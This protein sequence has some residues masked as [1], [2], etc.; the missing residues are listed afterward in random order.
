MNSRVSWSVDG[1]DPSVRERA[2]A[3]ARRAGMSL[4]D[5]LNSTIGEPIP[6]SFSAP[7]SQRPAMPSRESRDVADIHQRLDSITKQIEQ[8][9]R[10]AP[11]GETP[12]GE[13]PGEPTVA[14][15]LND[16]ISRLDARLSQISNPAPTRQAQMQ[17]KQRQ[18]EHG[19]AGR[20]P[21]LSP[22]AAAQSGLAGF[23][24]RRNRRA[25]E[26]TRQSA[27]APDAAAPCRADGRSRPAQFLAAQFCATRD[28]GGAGRSGLFF[29][30]TAPAQ[31]HQPD[32]GAAASRS[33]RG[34][35]CR[36]PQRT[37]RN[38]SS[39]HRGGAAPR[40]RIAR[41][42][43]PLAVPPHRRQQTERQ[44]RPDAGRHRTRARRNP[45]G[46]GLDDAGRAAHR[47]RR[48]DPQSRRQARSDP[49]FERRPVDRAAAR[50]R[51][52]GAARHRL[53]R[54]LQR[55][56]GPARRRRAHAVGQGRPASRA[57][58]AT[59]MPSA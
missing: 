39:H 46:A 15:Q 37:R 14:R 24:D 23:C 25:P 49:A 47:L 58:T 18:T 1:I 48:G 45:R 9:S 8:I 21:G 44:R 11:R 43:N 20:S 12:R 53:Q 29:A 5:W 59:A 51:D 40:D 55:R 2:E 7:S 33:C 41:E 3:A 31:D 32:R 16:A 50:K 17:E 35:D 28:A 10:P 27:A 30:R 19:R 42:R 57:S 38:P 4:S 52:R 6:P 34:V 54:R 22:R 13:A 36:V 26:R 56:A